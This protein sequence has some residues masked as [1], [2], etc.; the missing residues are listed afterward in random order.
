VA[1]GQPWSDW[2]ILADALAGWRAAWTGR[3]LFRCA[4]GPDWLRLNLEGDERPGLLLT[5]M[6]GAALIL[7]GCGPLPDP[8]HRAL[9]RT[10]KH[11]LPALLGG[12]SLTGVGLLPDDRVAALRFHKEGTGTLVLLH[13]LFGPRGNISLLDEQ[14]RILWA[15]QRPPHSLLTVH[16]PKGTWNTGTEQ[17]ADPLSASVLDH[18]ARQSAL[19][20]E[21]ENGSALNR[22]LGAAHRL[23]TNLEKDLTRAE[24]GDEFRRRAEALAAHLH[25]IAPGT[26]TASLT[27]P[28]DGSALE[29]ELDPSLSPSANLEAWFRRARKAD[30]GREIIRARFVDATAQVQI[31]EEAWREFEALPDAAAPPLEQLAARQ[32]W[33]AEHQDL[34]PQAKAGRS[35]G[36]RGLGPEEPARPFRRYMLDG[37][38]EVWIGRNNKENDTLTFGASHNKD[39]WMH[40]QGV[41]GSHLILRTKGNPEHVPRGIIEKAAALAA[42]HC[43]SKHSSLVPV[44]WTERRYVRK[45]RKSPPGTAT[46]LRE[47][48]LFVEPH[49]P[50]G[51]ESI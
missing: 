45:P 19:R 7:A 46:C 49:I 24:K 26:S 37:R 40:A 44:I 13:Q 33:A 29:I 20:L 36:R 28:R 25:E 1:S 50:A 9:Q 27:D 31:L 51:A 32:G 15:T 8:L 12:C 2:T 41:P 3:A 18:L 48:S 22:L 47:K 35:A 10:P 43:R 4:A 30:K 6:P 11:P 34:L 23:V 5:T 17:S 21:Q 39:I 16:P 42:L 14:G 38:W